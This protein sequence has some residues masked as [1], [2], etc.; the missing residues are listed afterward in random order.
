MSLNVDRTVDVV[1]VGGGPAGLAA[2]LAAGRLGASTVV[3]EA[4]PEPGGPTR[5][6]RTRGYTFDCS[7]HVLHLSHA[8]TR[9]LVDRVAGFGFRTFSVDDHNYLFYRAS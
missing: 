5:S 4:G 8:D 2:A 3:L 7:G 1:I 9:R 6:L